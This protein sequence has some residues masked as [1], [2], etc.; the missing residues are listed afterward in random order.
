MDTSRMPESTMPPLLEFEGVSFAY[1]DGEPG[2]SACSLTISEGSRNALIGANGAGK[3]TLFL[4]ANG[5][6]RPQAGT[7]RYAGRPIEYSRAGLRRLRSDVGIVFQNPDQQLFSASVFED[8][9]F[10]PLNLGLDPES[11]R[12]RVEAALDAVRMSE[13]SGRLAHNLSFGQR[14]RICIAGVLAMRPRL[15]ILDEPMAGLDHAMQKDLLSVLDD[16]HARGITLFLATHDIDFAYR[17][18]D[19]IHLMTAGRCAAAFDAEDLAENAGALESAGLPLPDVV[20]LY[21]RLV[22]DGVAAPGRVP[23]C[24]EEVLDLLTQR[25]IQ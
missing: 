10:G 18:A 4:H 24:V 8:V 22:T 15:L 1:P 17:W 6:F 23:R 12:E 5:L 13:F 20:G 2:L 3:T 19:R 21:R 7:V 11:A 14:K 25:S 9:S 16:M